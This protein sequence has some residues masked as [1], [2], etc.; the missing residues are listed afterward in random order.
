VRRT[1]DLLEIVC[2][3]NLED[4]KKIK[5]M[6]S[7]LRPFTDKDFHIGKESVSEY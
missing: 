5:M 1:R 2:P 4:R 7:L 3:E 6:Y